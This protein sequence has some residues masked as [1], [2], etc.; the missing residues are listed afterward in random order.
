MKSNRFLLNVGVDEQSALNYT[1]TVLLVGKTVRRTANAKAVT[2]TKITK[3]KRRKLSLKRNPRTQQPS[4]MIFQTIT[5]FVIVLN[6]IATKGTVNVFKVE[7]AVGLIADA[8]IVKTCRMATGLFKVI[9]Y[10]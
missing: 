2:T 6:R 10:E 5:K 4:V 9:I 1:A 3:K 7:E 8:S